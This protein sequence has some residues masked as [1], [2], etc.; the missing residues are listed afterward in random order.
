MPVIANRCLSPLPVHLQDRVVLLGYLSREDVL[1][2]VSHADVLVMVRGNDLQSQASY[3][4]KLSEFL[5][6]L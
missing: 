2:Y 6:E 3:P 1:S 5:Q 4:S